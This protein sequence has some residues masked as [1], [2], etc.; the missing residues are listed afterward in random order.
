MTRLNI[1][2]QNAII[3]SHQSEAH[4]VKPLTLPHFQ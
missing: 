1:M 4:Q 3:A 2:R